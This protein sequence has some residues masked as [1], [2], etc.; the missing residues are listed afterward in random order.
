MY[1]AERLGHFGDMNCT[2]MNAIC[3]PICLSLNEK[4]RV[5]LAASQYTQFSTLL[6]VPTEPWK[7]PVAMDKSLEGDNVLFIRL[8]L[9]D[10]G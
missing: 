5:S 8:L 6:Y 10:A 9:T 4:H 3:V 2:L 1:E 7:L